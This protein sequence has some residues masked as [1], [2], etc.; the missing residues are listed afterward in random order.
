MMLCCACWAGSASAGYGQTGGEQA[1]LPARATGSGE[2]VPPIEIADWEQRRQELRQWMD[3]YAAWKKWNEKWGNRVEPGWLGARPRRLR[4]EP[5]AWLSG[6]CPTPD[7]DEP[8]VVE[9]CQLLAEWNNEGLAQLRRQTTAARIQKEAPVH[10]Q[11]WEHVH[12]DALWMMTQWGTPVYGV[13]GMHATLEIA[14]RLQVF[15]APGVLL[16]NLPGID[17]TREWK[18]ATDWG[19]AYRLADFRFPGTQRLGSLHV[20]F[21]KAWVLSGPSNL[22]N[23]SID[24]AGFS[25]TPKQIH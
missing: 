3:A 19:F 7:D 13:V 8:M 2:P 20:N 23:T 9:A 4:P 14:G 18:P 24:L 1:P 17:G 15:V 6:E 11:W 12:V 25:I 5:P 16:L 10:T 22:L 21:A